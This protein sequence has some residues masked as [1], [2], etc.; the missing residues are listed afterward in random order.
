MAGTLQQLVIAMSAFFGQPDFQHTT[1]MNYDSPDTLEASQLF[2]TTVSLPSGGAVQTVDLPTLFPAAT[3]V[4]FVGIIDITN[5]GQAFIID[6]FANMAI[7]AGAG[8]CW[9]QNGGAPP[10]IQMHNPS[11][12][13]AA[14][15]MIV[16]A[17]Q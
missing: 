5:G 6:T 4:Q 3:A 14:Q 12:T 7:A 9:Q 2:E 13:Q 8:M 1:L 15:V 10:S 11:A 17:S 16:I